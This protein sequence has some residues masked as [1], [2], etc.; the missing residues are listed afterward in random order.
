MVK[1]RRKKRTAE[2]NVF[3]KSGSD[4]S[5]DAK[6]QVDLSIG[7]QAYEEFQAKR[8]EEIEKKAK[9]E[10]FHEK[11]E[12][13]NRL[14]RTNQLKKQRLAEAYDVGKKKYRRYMSKETQVKKMT[15]VIEGGLDRHIPKK[16][17]NDELYDDGI[18]GDEFSH[19]AAKDYKQEFRQKREVPTVDTNNDGV[20]D[21]Q[22]EV[23]MTPG[24]RR[25]AK[26]M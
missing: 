10:P 4:S 25:L 17:F 2:D 26:Y 6:E 7:T 23:Q 14:L 20:I 21:G 18:S 16:D 22:D 19:E 3:L 24:M 12:T 11:L 1:R 13:E 15:G 5:N 9:E 8:S